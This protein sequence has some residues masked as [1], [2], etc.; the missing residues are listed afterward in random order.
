MGNGLAVIAA[1]GVGCGTSGTG[2]PP[3]T[4]AVTGGVSGTPFA[5]AS[6]ASASDACGD[7]TAHVQ[8][9]NAQYLDV[10]VEN[11][12]GTT[13]TAPTSAGDYGVLV[14]PGASAQVQVTL[15]DATCTDTLNFQVHAIHG[16][17]TLA[18]IDTDYYAG[19][20]D[21][22]LTTGDHVTGSFVPEP[23]PALATPTG[24]TCM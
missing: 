6:A 3:T 11:Q 19:L 12:T 21:I 14:F 18:A 13:T 1:L 23:C 20:F 4:T 5:I 15:N 7:A 8:R 9:A 16:T 22:T 24:L 17:V 2:P 10:T